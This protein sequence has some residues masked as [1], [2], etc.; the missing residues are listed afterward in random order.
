MADCPLLSFLLI[1]ADTA[2]CLKVD[3]AF[4]GSSQTD[5]GQNEFVS[6]Q[7]LVFSTVVLPVSLYLTPF[8]CFV[9][10]W[11]GS[12]CQG[13]KVST[14]CV[15]FSSVL[16]SSSQ[17]PCLRRWTERTSHGAF[18]CDVNTDLNEGLPFC[19]AMPWSLE[20]SC[21]YVTHAAFIRRNIITEQ[22]GRVRK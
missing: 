4:A 10:D 6:L 22:T 21:H 16:P 15:S 20:L 19:P 1:D 7:I 11:F 2:D 14:S 12:G 5:W 13:F 3:V 9:C 18:Q 17:K 8:P